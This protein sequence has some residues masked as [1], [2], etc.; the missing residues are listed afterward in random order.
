MTTPDELVA[1][2]DRIRDGIQ[3]ERDILLLGQWLKNSNDYNVLQLG[4][5]IINIADGKD[6]HIGDRTY[7][8]TDAASIKAVLREVLTELIDTINPEK[9]PQQNSQIYLMANFLPQTTNEN[10]VVTSNS[11]T[12]QLPPN[13]P[14]ITKFE[15]EVVTIDTQGIEIKRCLKQAEYFIESLA[16]SVILEMVSIAGGKFQMGA[17]LDE[18]ESLEDE[19]PQ[20]LVTIK[21]FF[22]GKYLITQAQWRVIANLPKIKRRLE[23]EPSCF[24]GDN[25][26]VERVSWYDAQEFCERLSRKIGRKYRLSSEAEWEYACRAKT[27]TPFHF[28]KIIRP[29]LANYCG[30]N[31]NINSTACQQTTEVG[32][33]PANAF[34]IYDMHGLVWEWC[35]D[36]EHE[37]YQGAPLDGSSWLNDGNS[38]YRI[39]R[40]GS[41][42]S[43]A[44]LCRSASRFSEDASITD[45]KFGF[46]VVCS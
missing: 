33:F 15:F 17:P 22:I 42:N 29:N 24:K 19:R 6:I 40:G 9:S 25:L 10:A 8:N 38:E 45:K 16:D 13:L 44:H 20:H 46:R 27:S 4:K 11:L 26:P 41:W 2:F 23:L 32:S 7:Y 30:L 31:E 35:A 28:G 1:I 34:G 18:S 12:Q 3:D 37:D 14:A 43:P 21:P 39:L 5:N 36:C